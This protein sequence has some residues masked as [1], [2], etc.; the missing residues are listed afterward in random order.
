MIDSESDESPY[1]GNQRRVED[2]ST[3]LEPFDFGEAPETVL[4]ALERNRRLL[5]ETPREVRCDAKAVRKKIDELLD[6]L[7]EANYVRPRGHWKDEA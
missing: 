1:P 4:R 3:K 6:R 5:H 7:L 2:T